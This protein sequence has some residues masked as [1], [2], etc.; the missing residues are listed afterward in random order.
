MD[1]L[2]HCT[3]DRKSSFLTRVSIILNRFTSSS[4]L[5]LFIIISISYPPMSASL[6]ISF[7]YKITTIFIR[8]RNCITIAE[9]I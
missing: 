1:R 4:F 8:V 6:C 2:R 3:I 7:Y 9:A 5:F